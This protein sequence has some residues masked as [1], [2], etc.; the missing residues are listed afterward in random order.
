[1]STLPERREKGRAKMD[2]Y[3]SYSDGL[4]V[5]VKATSE[6]HAQERIMPIIE[7]LG[8]ECELDFLLDDLDEAEMMTAD[9]EIT[10]QQ[11]LED[12]E[13]DFNESKAILYEKFEDIVQVVEL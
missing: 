5:M 4:M 1:M 10:V 6:E 3:S 8:L 13:I 7:K 9:G 2:T 12:R 11:W